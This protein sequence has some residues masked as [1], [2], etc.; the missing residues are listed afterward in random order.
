MAVIRNFPKEDIK[1]IVAQ[2]EEL[3]LE[4][5]Q[6]KWIWEIRYFK[7]KKRVVE[8]SQFVSY[9]PNDTA[10]LTILINGGYRDEE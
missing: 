8:E 9:K 5:D 10:T 6:K 4:A 1:K 7:G 2:V 3:L